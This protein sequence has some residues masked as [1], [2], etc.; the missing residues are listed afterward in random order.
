MLFCGAVSQNAIMAFLLFLGRCP[1]FLNKSLTSAPPYSNLSQYSVA[2]FAEYQKALKKAKV[3]FEIV[4]YYDIFFI[5]LQQKQ[6]SSKHRR[7]C[8]ICCLSTSALRHRSGDDVTSNGK[9]GGG[10]RGSNG[11]SKGS[12]LCCPKCGEPCTHVETFVCK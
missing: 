12:Q 3:G 11:G 6:V 1:G 10:D 4:W 8:Q 7:V 9:S 5:V 2:V